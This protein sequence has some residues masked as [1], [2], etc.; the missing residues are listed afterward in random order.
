MWN[1]SDIPYV[2]FDGD[3]A[4]QNAAKKI[5]EKVLKFL[6]PGKSL[7]FISIP[8]NL[9]P[10]SFLRNKKKEDFLA[11]KKKAK[12]LSEIIWEGI[13]NSI[14]NNTPESIALIDNKINDVVKK[15]D[16]IKVSKEYFRFLKS[17]KESFIWDIN[18]TKTISTRRTNPNKIIENINEKLFLVMIIFYK[19]YLL[20]YQEEIFQIKLSNGI[21]EVI[22]TEVLKNYDAESKYIHEEENKYKSLT[23]NLL[24]E[25]KELKKTH[26]ACLSEEEKKVFFRQILNNLRL[27]K[28]LEERKF[29]EKQI[30]ESSEKLISE[31]LLNKYNK[32]SSEIKN[33]QNKRL[34]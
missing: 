26:A 6:L 24:G 17:K 20:D 10:D 7:R 25:I 32:I 13:V 22:K 3:D 23:P 28:L 15:I 18:K 1:Y 34:E 27:P 2:C 11:L 14:K 5:A 16:D 19:K 21:L 33:I 9:D 29:I 31:N 8:E 30:I 12:D 4:G